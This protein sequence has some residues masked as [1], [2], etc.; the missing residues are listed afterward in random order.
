MKLANKKHSDIRKQSPH[1][2]YAAFMAILNMSLRNEIFT[3]KN[4]FIISFWIKIY[5]DMY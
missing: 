3:F 5:K 2:L 1:C 4:C